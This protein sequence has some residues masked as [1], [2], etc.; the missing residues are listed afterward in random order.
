MARPGKGLGSGGSGVCLCLIVTG[1]SFSKHSVTLVMLSAEC[2]AVSSSPWGFG[3]GFP[4]IPCTPGLMVSTP[5]RSPA[6]LV[7]PTC[8]IVLGYDRQPGQ[9]CAVEG[10]LVKR[11][12]NGRVSDSTQGGLRGFG[13]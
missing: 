1:M 5:Q 9:N 11:S 3:G 8:W 7:N 10:I 12:R 2:V 4:Q 13:R 6:G